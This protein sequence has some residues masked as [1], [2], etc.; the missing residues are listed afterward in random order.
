[1][2]I[3]ICPS[4]CQF[5]Q[6]PLL[7]LGNILIF[8]DQDML[9]TMIQ[10]KHQISGIIFYTE[11]VLGSGRDFYKINLI[12]FPE[13]QP[14]FSMG[15]PQQFRQYFKYRPLLLGIEWLRETLNLLKTLLKSV[16]LIESLKEIFK[17]LLE[18]LIILARWKSLI[19][20]KLFPPCSTIGQTGF[21]DSLPKVEIPG[22]RFQQIVKGLIRTDYAKVS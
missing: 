2:S 4:G 17:P 16:N 1:M 22:I 21:C 9:D 8:I 11:C 10:I 3:G 19:D 15:S 13:Q 18:S 5:F 6:Q 12:S 7:A 14:Q 20:R